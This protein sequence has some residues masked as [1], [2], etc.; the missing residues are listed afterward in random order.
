MTKEEYSNNPKLCPYCD[1]PIPYEKRRNK[2]CNHSCAASFNNVGVTR[3]INSGKFKKKLCAEC[4]IITYNIKFCSRKCFNK[5][6]RKA[7]EEIMEAGLYK[8]SSSGDTPFRRYILRKRGHK[9]EE[10]GRAKWLGKKIP[11][12]L[13]HENGDSMDNRLENVKLLCLNCHGLTP[14]FGR[15]NKKSTRVDR[16]KK[17]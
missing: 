14:T 2:Y 1:Q 6:Q 3:N 12:D 15:L 9:C 17:K 8:T 5:N 10:C 13:H 4:G 11:L 16:Y 7:L